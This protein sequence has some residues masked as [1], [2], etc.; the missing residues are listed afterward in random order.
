MMPIRKDHEISWTPYENCHDGVGTLLCKSLLDG[1]GSTMFRHMHCDEH[2]AG[3]SI[4]SHK[5]V[6]SEEIYYLVSGRGI[7]I[8]NDE[9]FDMLPGD[10][11]LCNIGQSHGF[12]AIDDSVLIVVG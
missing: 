3:V 1:C 4:G 9:E 7:L 12:T 5:H 2:R 6:E 10:V 11:S 8:Y